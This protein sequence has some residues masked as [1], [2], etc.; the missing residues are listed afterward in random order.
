MSNAI[1]IKEGRI[2]TESNATKDAKKNENK[3]KRQTTF[4]SPSEK[5][6]RRLNIK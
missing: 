6:D 5:S 2:Q 1:N 3:T 4:L